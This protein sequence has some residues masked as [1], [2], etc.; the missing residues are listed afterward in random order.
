M[1]RRTGS[2]GNFTCP[3]DYRTTVI[4]AAE[5]DQ[6]TAHDARDKAAKRRLAPMIF[7]PV[8]GRWIPGFS[9]RWTAGAAMGFID[10]RSVRLVAA[11]LHRESLPDELE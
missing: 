7:T 10:R 6:S 8:T 2:R 4:T 1:I 11:V 3:E 9:R 5:E